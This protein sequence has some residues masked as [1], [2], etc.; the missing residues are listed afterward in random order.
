MWSWISLAC[1][2][3]ATASMALLPEEFIASLSGGNCGTFGFNC[4]A[5]S[6][7]IASVGYIAGIG[8]GIVGLVKADKASFFAWVVPVINALPFIGVI[9]I[10]ALR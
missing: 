10:F 4:L 9:L 8:A 6:L 3:C 2:I 7:A 5:I 1:F